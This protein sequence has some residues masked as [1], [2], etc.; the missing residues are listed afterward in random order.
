MNILLDTH[1][2]IWLAIEPQK[3]STQAT[4][5]LRDSNNTL[6]FSLVSIWEM[7][8]KIQL[9]KLTLNLPLSEV[10]DRQQQVNGL[11]ILPIELAHIFALEQLPNPHRDP[12]DRLLIAQ[13][14]V[15]QIPILSIDIIFDRYPVQRLW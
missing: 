4:Q 11:Q 10:I 7:Q 14:F 15:S 5:I 12:F 13:V 2:L 9:N 8:I 6:F 1:V 3:L